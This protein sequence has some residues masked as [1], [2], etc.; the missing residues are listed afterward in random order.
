MQFGS[1]KYW[2]H[3]HTHVDYKELV[4]QNAS[5]ILTFILPIFD[6]EIIACKFSIKIYLLYIVLSYE[7]GEKLLPVILLHIYN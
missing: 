6:T 7:M 2:F 4:V 1:K 5:L 3:T